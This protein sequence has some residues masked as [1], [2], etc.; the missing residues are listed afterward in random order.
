MYPGLLTSCST[1]YELNVA[2][3]ILKNGG[4][5]KCVDY[6]DSNGLCAKPISCRYS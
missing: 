4:D 3:Y 2:G 5:L 6:L 1:L